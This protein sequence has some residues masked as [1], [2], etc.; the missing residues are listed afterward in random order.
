MSFVKKQENNYLH[1][2]SP[3]EIALLEGIPL[4][5]LRKAAAGLTR[6]KLKLQFTGWLQYI[7]PVFFI[8][9][10]SFIGVNHA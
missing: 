6:L 10:F 3:N 9:L 5:I 4:L 7:I 2:L 1:G 8:F